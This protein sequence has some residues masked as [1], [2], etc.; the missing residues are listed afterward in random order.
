[1][2]NEV[3]SSEIK[4]GDIIAPWFEKQAKV[5][6]I[7]PYPSFRVAI[8]E[9]YPNKESGFNCSRIILYPKEKIQRING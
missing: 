7:I 9:P 6:N 2:M 1:M 3:D 4:V 8:M 5:I